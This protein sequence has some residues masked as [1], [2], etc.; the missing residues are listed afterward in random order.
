MTYYRKILSLILL[1]TTLC[2]FG[3]ADNKNVN[4]AES[5]RID[6]MT[7]CFDKHKFRKTKIIG[8]E[9]LDSIAGVSFEKIEKETF[10]NKTKY[11]LLSKSNKTIEL[12]L[13]ND[14]LVKA[15]VFDDK[16]YNDFWI[17]YYFRNDNVFL[18]VASPWDRRL[19]LAENEIRLIQLTKKLTSE[20]T[21][22]TK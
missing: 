17:R 8:S 4:F 10:K 3:Q 9:E 7:S 1:T 16:K 13:I 19:P 12:F 11:F 14:T 15:V 5:K 21:S 18:S 6:T 20:M 22:I 2:V